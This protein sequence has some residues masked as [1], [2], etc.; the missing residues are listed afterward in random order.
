MTEFIITLAFSFG[1][2]DRVPLPVW[3]KQTKGLHSSPPPSEIYQTGFQP[4]EARYRKNERHQ[5][6]LSWAVYVRIRE[7]FEFL[8]MAT[9]LLVL[10]M[11]KIH[12]FTFFFYVISSRESKDPQQLIK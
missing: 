11:S 8:A 6:I 12:V 4:N 5:K 2:S 9:P 7:K 3:A 1:E 10:F